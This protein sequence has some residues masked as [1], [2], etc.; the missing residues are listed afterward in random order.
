MQQ[1]CEI[2]AAADSSFGGHTCTITFTKERLCP[3]EVIHAQLHT[4]KRDYVAT[5]KYKITW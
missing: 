5:Q 2:Q 4:P 3:S 1:Q